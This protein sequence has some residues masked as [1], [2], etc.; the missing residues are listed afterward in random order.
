MRRIRSSAERRR[1]ISRRP[2]RSVTSTSF[3][4]AL[5]IASLGLSAGGWVC[6]V[7]FTILLHLHPLRGDPAQAH[8]DVLVL[9]D[10]A[11]ILEPELDGVIAVL[12]DRAVDLG[13]RLGDAAGAEGSP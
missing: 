3:F 10:G 11:G 9:V 8:L 2:S 6:G 4:A 1:T 13:D 5:T 7:T 12:G